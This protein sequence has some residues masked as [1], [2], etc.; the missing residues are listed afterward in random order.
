MGNS[1]GE[2]GSVEVQDPVCI[3]ER[4]FWPGRELELGENGRDSDTS[5]RKVTRPLATLGVIQGAFQREP[6]KY[7]L[8][9][10]SRLICEP[11]VSPTNGLSRC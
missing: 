8:H 3:L 5:V 6:P 11:C 7:K 4:S 1:T 9:L 2:L 10:F